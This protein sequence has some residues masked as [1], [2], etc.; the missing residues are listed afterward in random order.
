MKILA[1][2]VLATLIPA[3]TLADTNPATVD[4]AKSWL[5][6]LDAGNYGQSWNAASS[7]FRGRI[8]QAQ[9]ETAVRSARTPLG[10]VVKRAVASVDLATTLP[11]APDGHYAVIKFDTTFA[12]K[13]AAIETVIMMM[14]GGT[15]KTAGYFVR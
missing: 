3:M 8:S 4:S 9:W 14:D 2:I 10:A 15:W 6:V 13:A 12:N 1:A 5:A 11:G 7:L